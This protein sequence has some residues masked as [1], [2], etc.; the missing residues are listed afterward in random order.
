MEPKIPQ[1]P[2][3]PT[4]EEKT[5]AMLNIVGAGTI[6]S[7]QGGNYK[8]AETPSEGNKNKYILTHEKR[9]TDLQTYQRTTGGCFFSERQSGD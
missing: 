1:K 5:A 4:I 7:Y 9:Q 3:E 6:I 8:V 2:T